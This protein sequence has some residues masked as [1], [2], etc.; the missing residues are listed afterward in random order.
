MA[1]QD[2]SRRH[3]WSSRAR[4]TMMEALRYSR[5]VVL[6]KR[7]LSLGAFLIIAACWPSSSSPAGPASCR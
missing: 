4:S 5:F 6:A 2:Q 3:D 1:A 7:V